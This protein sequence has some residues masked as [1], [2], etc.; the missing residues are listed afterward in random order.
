MKAKIEIVPIYNDFCKPYD[1][2]IVRNAVN[3]LTGE[4]GSYSISDRHADSMYLQ[5]NKL[6]AIDEKGDVIASYP[7]TDDT[8]PISKQTVQA[9]IDAGCPQECEY[10][11][12]EFIEGSYLHHCKICNNKFFGDKYFYICHD[13]CDKPNT[14]TNGCIVLTFE[15]A[16][17]K[18]NVSDAEIEA[19]AEKYS[20][21]SILYE[22]FNTMVCLQSGFRD[23]Y[24]QALIDH[25]L[26]PKQ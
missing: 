5:A 2:V 24:N 6:N 14:D 10:E 17:D 26:K 1:L 3:G 18:P 11:T 13:C 12:T 4:I 9:W 21:D 8:L 15:K 25:N 16:Q 23:G 7:K 20:S 22:D 19:K